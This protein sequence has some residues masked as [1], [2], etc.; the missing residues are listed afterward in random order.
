MPEFYT[1]IAQKIFFPEFW[2]AHA[3][4]LSPVSCAYVQMYDLLV[5]MFL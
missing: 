5:L 3:H 2:G 4:P 1:I